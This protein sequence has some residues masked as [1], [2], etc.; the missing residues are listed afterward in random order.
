MFFRRLFWYA[1]PSSLVSIQDSIMTRKIIT[2]QEALSNISKLQFYDHFF[3][4]WFGLN[5]VAK[6]EVSIRQLM[7]LAAMY[8]LAGNY[9]R[10][11]KLKLRAEKCMLWGIVN[12]LY[13]TNPVKF[14]SAEK[15]FDFYAW[16][17]T[18]DTFY[19]R[20]KNLKYNF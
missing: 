2:R 3:I 7:I 12:K 6:G 8:N 17:F 20:L 10:A 19:I 5:K 9:P 13:I 11:K 15:S 14:E 1:L 18:P 16:V 4:P